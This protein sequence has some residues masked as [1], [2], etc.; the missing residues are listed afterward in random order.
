[1]HSRVAEQKVGSFPSP[2]SPAQGASLG[3]LWCSERLYHTAQMGPSQTPPETE[4][5]PCRQ[6]H[7]PRDTP[8]QIDPWTHQETQ[9]NTDIQRHHSRTPPQTDT[10]TPRDT[11]RLNRHRDRKTHRV[12]EKHRETQIDVETTQ[13]DT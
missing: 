7:T 12:T 2:M 11:P 3:I 6:T 9:R 1:M 13:T 10:H 5:H 8:R 4:R